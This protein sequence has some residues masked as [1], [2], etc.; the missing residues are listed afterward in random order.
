MIQLNR[1]SSLEYVISQ[2]SESLVVE[3]SDADAAADAE[4]QQIDVA[5]DDVER[6]DAGF[7]ADGLNGI[8]IDVQADRLL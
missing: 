7:G 1:Y 8:P 3:T 4:A 2:H 6:D 5:D